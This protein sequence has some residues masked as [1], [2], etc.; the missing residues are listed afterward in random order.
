MTQTKTIADAGST[1]AGSTIL[2]KKMMFIL[3]FI[4]IAGLETADANEE[5]TTDPPIEVSEKPDEHDMCVG[6]VDRKKEI[7]PEPKLEVEIRIDPLT[8]DIRYIIKGLVIE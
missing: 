8:G 1:P 3:T 4:L 2:E 6:C 5:P 7:Q